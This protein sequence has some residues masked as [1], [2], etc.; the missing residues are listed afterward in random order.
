MVL[1]FSKFRLQFYLAIVPILNIF[2]KQYPFHHIISTFH[3]MENH[4]CFQGL[5]RWFNYKLRTS[6]AYFICKC[7]NYSWL[8]IC[9]M[10][11]HLN[12]VAE[13]KCFSHLFSSFDFQHFFVFY[14]ILSEFLPSLLFWNHN[15]NNFICYSPTIV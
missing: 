11:W 12:F 1:H 9:I 5:N 8:I 10:T 13:I 3:I 7:K 14:G 4:N 15:Y 2:W 6:M